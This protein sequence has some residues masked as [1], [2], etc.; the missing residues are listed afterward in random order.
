L[1]RRSGTGGSVIERHEH[2]SAA[3]AF[4]SPHA[5]LQVRE[6]GRRREVSLLCVLELPPAPDPPN[7]ALLKGVDA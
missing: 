5:T 2:R 4:K 1:R 3:R 7:E 6:V